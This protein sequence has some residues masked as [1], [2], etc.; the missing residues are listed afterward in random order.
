MKEKHK[1]KIFIG[2]IAIL[3]I[4]V[5]YLLMKPATTVYL[6]STTTNNPTNTVNGICSNGQPYGCTIVCT[7]GPTPTRD[8]TTDD[9]PRDGTTCRN[10]AT[11]QKYSASAWDTT[12]TSLT[13]CQTYA[14]NHGCSVPSKIN[15]V[16]NCCMWT[17]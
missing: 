13:G 8:T 14:L 16:N 15:I 1:L 9:L 3:V 17:C 10:Y 5:I 7:N 6:N 12:V 4:I 2:I 11:D